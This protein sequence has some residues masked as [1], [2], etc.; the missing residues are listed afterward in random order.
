M[1]HKPRIQ[2]KIGTHSSTELVLWNDKQEIKI[3]SKILAMESKLYDS[4]HSQWRR[5]KSCDYWQHYLI[6]ETE[7]IVFVSK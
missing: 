4:L 7:P 2:A 6:T 1:Y 3:G 5:L